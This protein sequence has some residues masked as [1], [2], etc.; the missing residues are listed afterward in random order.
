MEVVRFQNV[1][2]HISIR[3]VVYLINLCRAYVM[4]NLVSSFILHSLKVTKCL[5]KD[6]VVRTTS[7]T[8][9]QL[10]VCGVF[11]K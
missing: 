10:T 3:N 9:S 6:L 11:D 4:S 8:L 7:N 2:H 5:I 1:P